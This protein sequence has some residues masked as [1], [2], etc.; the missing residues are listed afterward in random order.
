MKMTRLW[1]FSCCGGQVF[2]WYVGCVDFVVAV[3]AFEIVD[4]KKSTAAS[5]A[6]VATELGTNSS[7]M[8][9]LNLEILNE[10]SK[11]SI[12]FAYFQSRKALSVCICECILINVCV[13]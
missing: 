13:A 9:F 8:G 10:F 11:S 2:W 6:R 12:G 1:G 4:F 3:F 7:I 5:E